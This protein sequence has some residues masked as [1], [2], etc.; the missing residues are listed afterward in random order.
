MRKRIGGTIGAL[1][2]LALL[3]APAAPGF[4]PRAPAEFFGL[5]VNGLQDAPVPRD[6]P[7][8][9]AAHVEGIGDSG[10]GVG[11]FALSWRQHEPD[12]PWYGG[13]RYRW[14]ST[15]TIVEAIVGEGVRPYGTLVGTPW[16]ATTYERAWAC[17]GGQAA[18]TDLDSFAAFAAAA[19]GRYGPDG[20][21]WAERPELPKLPMRAVEVWNEPNW[22]AWCPV[23]EPDVYARLLIGAAEAIEAQDPA[24]SVV[25]GGLAAAKRGQA[26]PYGTPVDLFLERM[27]AAEPDVFDAVDAVGLHPYAGDPEDVLANVAAARRVIDRLGGAE[28]PLDLTEVG[29]PTR[30]AGSIRLAEEDRASAYA[31]LFHE[32]WR[33]DCGIVRAFPFTWRSPEE[34]PNDPSQWFGLA[35]PVTAAPYPSATAYSREI[36]LARGNGPQPAPRRLIPVCGRGAPDSDGD[37]YVDPADDFP[38][39]PGS[40]DG[41]NETNPEDVTATEPR[42]FPPRVPDGFFGIEGGVVWGDEVALRRAHFDAIA[43]H[44]FGRYRIKIAWPGL[45]P[46]ATVPPAD[47]VWAPIDAQVRHAANRGMQPQPYVAGKPAWAGNTVAAV[48][49]RY[50]G[51]IGALVRRYGPAGEFW[52]DNPGVPYLPV[53][54]WEV[55]SSA[56]ESVKW[57]DGSASPTEYADAYQAVRTELRSVDPGA[58]ALVSVVRKSSNITAGD[59]IRRMGIAV[60]GAVVDARFVSV[61][62]IG[63]TVV[64]VRAALGSPARELIPVVGFHTRGA[65]A[66][67]EALRVASFNGLY[68]GFARSNCNVTS[69]VVDAWATSEL[70]TADRYQWLGIAPPGAPGQPYPSA[71]AIAGQA[72]LFQGYASQPAPTA[73]NAYC[74]S[75]AADRDGDGAADP[76]DYYPTDATRRVQFNPAPTI[77]SAPAAS[78]ARTSAT[79][80][81]SRPDPA[82]VE[83]QCR[84]DGLGWVACS[85][86]AITYAGLAPG[87][88]WFEVRALDRLEVASPVAR[89]AW[90]VRGA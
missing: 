7:E 61:S 32:L 73:A 57:W 65:G 35:D 76:V 77:H 45:A 90:T 12:P 41:A 40:H 39:N 62:V 75:A 55:W 85:E 50:V 11:R 30:P 27:V 22:A 24:V 46:T 6:D 2:A 87:S 60:D 29:W 71:A 54:E 28:L 20:S 10:A 88:H 47:Y 84:R 4:T 89:H 33:T 36:E 72:A 74:G 53:R 1:L 31:E 8:A 81:F 80:T 68:D 83:L 26:P 17:Q 42:R 58:R 18:P 9:F 79:F 51:L 25:L 16:W 59:W 23:N 66:F 13:H 3:C 52:A 70:N 15:D 37:G 44:R 5:D 64:D 49:P 82:A 67:T 48:K 43:A 14:G 78:S 38:L 19:V 56:N 21:F 34:D 63:S 86:G 69:I